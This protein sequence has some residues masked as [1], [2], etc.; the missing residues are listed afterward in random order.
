M[1]VPDSGTGKNGVKTLAFRFRPELH[2]QITLVAGLRGHTLQDEVMAA[3]EAHVA[4]A[5]TDPELTS[6]VEAARA[7]IEQEAQERRATIAALFEADQATATDKPTKTTP[8]RTG[9][10]PA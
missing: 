2:S 5:K 1:S 8:G 4:T 7:E 3:I 6:K 9:S 10:K